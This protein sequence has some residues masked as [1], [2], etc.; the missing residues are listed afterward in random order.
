[1][2][3]LVWDSENRIIIAMFYKPIFVPACW[4]ESRTHLGIIATCYVIFRLSV[5][6]I[7]V[8]LTFV[9]PIYYW[10]KYIYIY[11]YISF[12]V[13]AMQKTI[14]F[15][16]SFSESFLWK[17]HCFKYYR[18]YHNSIPGLYTVAYTLSMEGLTWSSVTSYITCYVICSYTAQVTDPVR[19]KETYIQGRAYVRSA[20]S[21]SLGAL[22]YWEVRV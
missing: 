15:L 7:V 19:W 5:T 13:Q 22:V 8:Y 21:P 9:W 10:Y 16:L 6:L 4:R 17:F 20:W 3:S 2:I 11:T 14:Y 18:A 12:H 1:M